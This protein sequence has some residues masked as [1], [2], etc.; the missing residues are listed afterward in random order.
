MLMVY[1][2]DHLTEDSSRFRG[3]FVFDTLLYEQFRPTIKAAYRHMSKRRAMRMA[4]VVF[5]LDQMRT[6]A[7]LNTLCKKHISTSSFN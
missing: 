6:N 1:L 2:L 7:P 3:L 4:V 5:G